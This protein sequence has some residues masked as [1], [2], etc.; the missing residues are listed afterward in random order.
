MLNRSQVRRGNGPHFTDPTKDKAARR[1]LVALRASG[2]TRRSKGEWYRN[3]TPQRRV[4]SRAV[5][6][7]PCARTVARCGAQYHP[8]FVPRFAR[9]PAFRAP[10][11]Q[12]GPVQGPLS[13]R[14]S[15][16]LQPPQ[17]P[18]HRLPQP[19]F[20]TPFR[21]PPLFLPQ[22]GGVVLHIEPVALRYSTSSRSE[23]TYSSAV[24]SLKSTSW[25]GSTA[26]NTP[27]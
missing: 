26:P 5:S 4:T 24:I 15:S 10:E 7:P 17:I 23:Q 20:Q 16:L 2:L 3:A 6:P 21:L 27:P 25:G 13:S 8:S 19:L 18:P 22:R 1:R 11:T 12:K 9:N 14:A